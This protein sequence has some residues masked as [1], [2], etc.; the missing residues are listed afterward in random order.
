MIYNG[1]LKK[2]PA[3]LRK[4]LVESAGT[5][6]AWSASNEATISDKVTAGG[7]ATLC[8]EMIND[9][10]SGYT[11]TTL[12]TYV[13]QHYGLELNHDN[14]DLSGITITA[15]SH[16]NLYDWLADNPIP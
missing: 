1:S 8:E 7:L 4:A 10:T 5:R 6:S 14:L 3:M 2:T 9:K 15:I 12:G 11:L 13:K 16:P